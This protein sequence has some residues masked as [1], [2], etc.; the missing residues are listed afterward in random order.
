MGGARGGEQQEETSRG[1]NSWEAQLP[2]HV[3]DACHNTTLRGRP[4][5]HM[6]HY[7]QPSSFDA[8]VSI[9]FNLLILVKNVNGFGGMV[10][11]DKNIKEGQVPYH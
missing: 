10:V 11:F 4:I 7:A 2:A 6:L 9:I 1:L 8:F 3:P 5:C